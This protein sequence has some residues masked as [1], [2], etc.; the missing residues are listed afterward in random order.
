RNEKSRANGARNCPY[1]W[2][3]WCT[4]GRSRIAIGKPNNGGPAKSCG[5]GHVSDWGHQH[6][7]VSHECTPKTR[8]AIRLNQCSAESARYHRVPWRDI[9]LKAFSLFRSLLG[10]GSHKAKFRV[11]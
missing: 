10:R 11:Y 7:S 4:W 3:S 6:D 1:R 5:V 9:D 2:D 8:R